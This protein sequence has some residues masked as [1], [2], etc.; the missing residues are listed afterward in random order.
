VRPIAFDTETWLIAP[1]RLAPRLVCLSWCDGAGNGLLDRDEGLRWIREKLKDPTVVLVGHN[2]AYDFGV[3]CEADPSLLPLVFGAYDADRVIDTGIVEMLHLIALGRLGFDPALGRPPKFRLAELV[4]KHLGEKVEGKE[5]PDVWRLRYH[6]L[7]GVPI[8]TWPEAAREYARLDAAYTYRVA[9]RQYDHGTPA[10]LA[11][12]CRAAWALHLMGAWGLRTDPE[13][14]ASL[15]ATLTAHVEA[16][17]AKL[18]QAGLVRPDGSKDTKA[19]Q[20]RV[21]QAFGQDVIDSDPNRRTPGGGVRIDADTLRQS[22]DPDLQLLADIGEDAKEL[23]TYVPIL[24]RGTRRPINARFNVL[25]ASG[26][27]SCRGP[28]LQNQPRRPGVRECYIARPGT[29]LCSVDWNSAEMRTLAQL[30]VDWFGHSELAETLNAGRDPHLETAAHRLGITYE[31]A[32]ARYEAGDKEL[33]EHRTLSKAE[34]FGRP[35]GLGDDAFIAFARATYGLEITAERAAE[36]KASWFGRFPEMQYYFREISRRTNEGGGRFT[37]VVER[38][39]FVRGDVGYTDGCNHGFQH[40]VA[41]AGKAAC[42]RVAKECYLGVCSCGNPS[43]RAH[44]EACGGTGR[45]PL[46]GTRPV[47][48]IHDEILAEVPEATAHEAAHRLAEI[49]LEELK[50]LCPD[51]PVKAEPA[52][53]RR[54]YKGVKTVYDEHGRLVPWEPKRQEPKRQEPQRQEPAPAPLLI[55]PPSAPLP[56]ALPAWHGPVTPEN[57]DAYVSVHGHEPAFRYYNLETYREAVAGAGCQCRG[58]VTP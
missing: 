47:A 37:Y 12:Q 10:T 58:E 41:H 15:K 40:P 29:L 28:N 23:S 11:D 17:N 19:I 3:V 38:T 27:T 56:T 16:A 43:A 7:D 2:V 35:G 6:E 53:M 52:L 55:A 4:E 9:A 49:M 8:D 36:S 26:R 34:N 24:E 22:G 50:R 18:V 1:G 44:C 51:V 48:F 45:S 25:V 54:W 13:A 33:D 21:V 31:E 32:V 5:G 42:Y 39:G 30:L 14:V 57:L 20:A 46:Y